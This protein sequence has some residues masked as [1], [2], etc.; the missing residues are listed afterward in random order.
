MKI[1]FKKST[2]LILLFLWTKL[3][4]CQSTSKHF[5]KMPLI[6]GF[7]KIISGEQIS[8][9]SSYPQFANRALLTRCN[10][11][12]SS[13]SWQTSVAPMEL[14]EE[15][16]CFYWLSGHSC[17]TS[18]DNRSFDLQIN[19]KSYLTFVTPSQKNVP[20]IWE[21][22]GKDSVKLIFEATQTDIHNDAFGNMYLIVPKRLL[23]KGKPIEIKITGEK[24]NSPDWFMVFK[25]S[26]NQKFDLTVTPFLKKTSNGIKQELQ[27]QIDHIHNNINKIEFSINDKKFIENVKP[28]YNL[29]KIPLDT[30][31]KITNL[32]V[33]IKLNNKISYHY[34]VKQHPPSYREV[35]IIH[36]SHNDIG[37][38]HLQ[39]QVMEIQY[40]NILDALDEIDKTKGYPDESR[41]RWNI[42][43]SWPIEYFLAHATNHD[44][45]RFKNAVVNKSIAIGGFYAGVLSGLSSPEELFWLTEF[46]DSLRSKYNFQIT[47]AILS[48]IPGISWSVVDMMAK[49][50]I[51]YLSNG[52]NYIFNLPDKGDRIG[53]TLKELGDKPF[54]WKTT[55]G[56]DSI[57]VWT[58]GL[59][60]SAFHQISKNHLKEKIKF[61][62]ISYLT[63]LD[64][65]NYPYESIQLRYTIKSDNGPID[66]SL[67]DFVR[68]WNEEYYSPKLKISNINEVMEDFELKNGRSLPTYS[69]DFTPYWEDGAYSTTVEEGEVRRLS[70]YIQQLERL[71]EMNNSKQ[72]NN[73]QFYNAHKFVTLFHEHT[74]GSWNSISAPDDPFT[75]SQWNY[76]K[77]YID[78]VKHY[79][80]QIEK[81]LFIHIN[82]H[83]ILKIINTQEFTRTDYIEIDNPHKLSGNAMIDKY[84]NVFTVQNLK[85]G[86]I[87]F[88]AKNIPPKSVNTFEFVYID[89]L[90]SKNMINSNCKIDNITGAIKH[91]KV[92]D[93]DLF[94]TDSVFAFNQAIYITGDNPNNISQSK[95]ISID[96]VDDGAVVQT[97]RVNCSLK[98]CKSLVYEFSFY[99]DLKYIRLRTLI[100][101]SAERN[102]ES[103]HI[104]FPLKLEKPI[105]RIGIS[106]T[107]FLV[108]SGQIPGSNKDFYS[109]QRWIDVSNE[110]TGVTYSSPQVALFEIGQLNDEQ[111]L[112]GGY[113]K[114]SIKK[115]NSSTIFAYI[116]NNYWTTNFKAEQSGLIYIDSYV[117]P[118]KTF[119]LI[120]SCEFGKEIHFPL[121]SKWE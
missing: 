29:L 88:I 71:S 103:I 37:Y 33:E 107:F 116:L 11:G 5:E 91:I 38:S 36:H 73:F 80:Q 45:Q 66:K 34:V 57:L 111:P 112:N 120:Q 20:F 115:S 89:S 58:A 97:I 109:V 17:Q 51:R 105:N 35:N 100:D 15:Y 84:G 108:N 48:D 18:S 74:W 56:D 60:Y 2:L 28:G 10:T 6:S 63:E 72:G 3:L 40:Q 7:E 93:I 14:N 70:D 52:P 78:S 44:I 21:F 101:K 54:Y 117:Y 42:E 79:I 86:N 121:I 9:F 96:T 4:H 27:V 55:T 64:S 13:I 24:Q 92:N 113:K 23:K 53:G 81:S 47:T 65:L 85:N 114:W 46:T 22:N 118:H 1:L 110:N 19:G 98:G 25:Y 39:K 82:N 99:N 68:N 106:D 26:Y 43:I 102:K 75:I 49:K 62:L 95:I 67:S 16:Y 76:K 8:Y 94:T 41:F 69:G 119:N 30:V 31:N 59:G 32:D 12:N 77:S 104:A 83:K 87:C 61:K 90:V 50:K